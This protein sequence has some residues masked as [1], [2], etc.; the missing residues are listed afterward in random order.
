MSETGT[1]LD[2]EP[3]ETERLKSVYLSVTGGE[4]EPVVERQEPDSNT[5]EIPDDTPSDVVGPAEHHGL[6]DAI[7]DHEPG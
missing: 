6:D 5:R 4:T 3:N 7:D 1:E 2:T